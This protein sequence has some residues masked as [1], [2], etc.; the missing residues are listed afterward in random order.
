[1]SARLD[2]Y[3]VYNYRTHNTE[4]NYSAAAEQQQRQAML[5]FATM[6]CDDWSCS[7]VTGAI[8][9]GLTGGAVMP[10]FLAL[11]LGWSS[12]DCDTA[13]PCSI[14]GLVISSVALGFSCCGICG[15]C[16]DNSEQTAELRMPMRKMI[17]AN[18]L[19]LVINIAALAILAP[20]CS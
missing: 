16:E 13:Y 7:C 15:V 10:T 2:P 18:V 14:V 20:K 19:M 17:A 11:A 9:G 6:R 4:F 5:A 8:T 1:M 12:A 3:R